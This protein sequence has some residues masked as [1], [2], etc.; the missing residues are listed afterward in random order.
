VFLFCAS[1]IHEEGRENF[2]NFEISP[3]LL[4]PTKK[5]VGILRYLEFQ[6]LE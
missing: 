4:L 6:S 3:P 2:E 1:S 5:K